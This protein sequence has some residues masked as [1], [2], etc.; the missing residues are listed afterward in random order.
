MYL[1]MAGA[2]EVAAAFQIISAAA[3][4]ALVERGLHLK[5]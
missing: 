4:A 3:A 5:T 2:V 1:L